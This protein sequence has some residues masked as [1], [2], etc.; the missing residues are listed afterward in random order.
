MAEEERF[1]EVVVRGEQPIATSEDLRSALAM[2][3]R[4]ENAGILL[5]AG[6]STNA[7]G[8]TMA[9]LWKE[10]ATNHKNTI[11][12]LDGQN[13]REAGETNLETII[14]RVQLALLDSKRR[15]EDVNELTKSLKLLRQMVVQ[16]AVLD[17]DL[18]SNAERS[19]S[20]EELQD[21]RRLLTR[22]LAS[23]QPGQPAPAI[24]TTNYDLAVEW[25]AEALGVHV[26]NGFTGLHGRSFQPSIF[27]LSLRNTAAQG[28]ARF[29]AFD[30]S[31]VKLH[32]SLS[33]FE[34]DG[35]VLERPVGQCAEIL[36]KYL[37]DPSEPF[38]PLLI[39]PSAAKYVDTIGFVY[40]EMMR[41]FSE[42]MA[43]QHCC[44]ITCGYGFNDS[45]INRLISAGLQN[46]TMLL[47]AYYPGWKKLEDEIPNPFL[48]KLRSLGSPRIII[49]GGGAAA[50][51]HRLV[52]DLPDPT[53]ID[54]SASIIRRLATVLRDAGGDG[55]L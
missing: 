34:Q 26:V 51:L 22:V 55:D 5:G 9:Q 16:A 46:P 37:D 35:A 31:L 10:L 32:G 45:H 12:F 24:F 38:D 19:G 50:Y 33:W 39:Y 1:S 14:A 2:A 11:K 28:E 40:G 18:W 21:H 36:G 25:S 42:F 53:L 23:R 41:R 30:I 3:L 43:R 4:L 48:Q 6:A 52:N 44:L 17:Q 7:C 8:M 13:L 27:D 20:S 54:E 47:V 15:G 49:R 29:G